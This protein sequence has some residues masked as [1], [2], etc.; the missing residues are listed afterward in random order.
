MLER[1]LDYMQFS[2]NV[3]ERD[4]MDQKFDTVYPIQFYSRGYRHPLGYRIY[5]G[6]PNSKKALIVASADALSNMR[7]E[8]MLDAEILSYGLDLGAK[9][10]RID[11][12]VTDWQTFDGLLELKDVENWFKKGLIESPLAEHGCK[13]IA[14]IFP[15]G[16]EVQ[17]LYIGDIEK[18]GKRGIFR[19]YDKGIELD[20]GLYMATRI[21][22]ELRGSSANATARR[23]SESN[24]IAGNFRSKFNVR[25]KEFDRLM[26]ADAVDISRGKQIVGKEADEENDSRW[27]WLMKQVAPSLKKAIQQDIKS[28]KGTD[29]LNQFLIKSGMGKRGTKGLIDSVK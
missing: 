10:T 6:N 7:G 25:H 17:T 8:N 24:D 19:A 12:T 14:E 20:L 22:L 26:D 4:C 23:L 28:G 2:A 18:R 29:R 9:F 3:N 21:E 15:S 16:R 1:F 11:L 5:F 13:E 27:I